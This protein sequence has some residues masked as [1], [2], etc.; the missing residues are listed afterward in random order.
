[1]ITYYPAVISKEDDVW[2]VRFPDFEQINTFGDSLEEAI[3]AA[4]E[5]LNGCVATDFERGFDF[6]EPS[7]IQHDGVYNIPLEAHV[8]IALELRRLRENRSQIEI[9]REMGI[10]YQAYQRLEHPGKSNPTIKTLSKIARV[11]G[12]KLDIRFL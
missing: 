11:L 4:S 8:V 5:A 3:Q 1:M 7:L 2:M 9:A 12:K 6:P 10:S